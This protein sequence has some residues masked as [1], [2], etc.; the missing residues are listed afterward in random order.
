MV[1]GQLAHI[2]C[3][4]IEVSVPVPVAYK[5][6]A[7][8]SD[9]FKGNPKI[10]DFIP[11]GKVRSRGDGYVYK[12]A[13]IQPNR[14]C[15]M[16]SDGFKAKANAFFPANAEYQVSGGQWYKYGTGWA[17]TRLGRVMPEYRDIWIY[18]PKFVGQNGWKLMTQERVIGASSPGFVYSFING[19]SQ[20]DPDKYM[21]ANEFK[22]LF[23]ANQVYYVAE[24][25]WYFKGD[26]W[27]GARIAYY[28]D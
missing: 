26:G 4:D 10:W 15:W 11:G 24:S 19:T 17:W 25:W 28:Q 2:S 16:Y 22:R 18:S 6:V 8:Y 5:D 13:G 7:V 1:N 21:Y 12:F 20:V 14:G 3:G 23:R 9:A 27:A